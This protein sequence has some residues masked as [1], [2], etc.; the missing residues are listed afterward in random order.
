M[1]H[2]A[3]LVTKAADERSTVSLEG[4]GLALSFCLLWKG[5]ILEAGSTS[6]YMQDLGKRP[7]IIVFGDSLLGLANRPKSAQ[8]HDGGYV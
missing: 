8:N 6:P 7:H 1:A 2:Q 5:R 3:G 4:D